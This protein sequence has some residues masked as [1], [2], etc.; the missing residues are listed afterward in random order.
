MTTPNIQLNAKDITMTYQ[1]HNRYHNSNKYLRLLDRLSLIDITLVQRRFWP[2]EGTKLIFLNLR[3]EL[4]YWVS[5]GIQIAYFIASST[6]GA[7]HLSDGIMRF[8]QSNFHAINNGASKS[9]RSLGHDMVAMHQ[10]YNNGLPTALAIHLSFQ[11]E[12]KIKL[13]HEIEIT[14]TL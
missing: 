3:D 9:A 14:P 13:A 10:P 12:K 6:P 7:T 1:V 2:N 5:W 4:G 8:F 11:M